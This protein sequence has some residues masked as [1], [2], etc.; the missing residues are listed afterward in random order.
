METLLG[1]P[2]KAMNSLGWKT[3]I[4]FEELVYDMMN[5]DF[6]F[7]GMELP[8]N[9]LQYLPS[10]KLTKKFSY[11]DIERRQSNPNFANHPEVRRKSEKE[12]QNATVILAAK[13]F[14]EC[15]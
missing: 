15:T 10:K 3:D 8:E 12:D 4:G 2:T 5:H 11:P 9:A 1:D 7:Y 14:R 6:Q 13:S